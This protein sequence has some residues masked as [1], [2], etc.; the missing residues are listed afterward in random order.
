VSR[1]SRQCGILNISQPYRPQSRITGIALFFTFFYRCNRV[2]RRDL[3]SRGSKLSPV[4]SNRILVYAV[5][6][7]GKDMRQKAQ[8]MAL[9]SDEHLWMTTKVSKNSVA[10]ATSK[11]ECKGIKQNISTYRRLGFR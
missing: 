2:L 8:E 7:W 1:L 5:P 11:H 10:G 6:Y 9:L 4:D 3:D